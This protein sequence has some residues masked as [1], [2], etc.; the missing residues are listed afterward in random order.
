MTAPITI[1]VRDTD[2]E[3]RL[4]RFLRRRFPGL[5]QGRIELF[6]RRGLVKV[7]GERIKQ[8]GFRLEPGMSLAVHPAIAEEADASPAR[9]AHAVS[10]RRRAPAAVDDPA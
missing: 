6:L 4:D 7:D 9:G 3:A 10:A 8:S 5:T 2:G 1:P